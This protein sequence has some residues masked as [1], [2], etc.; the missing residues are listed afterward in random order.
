MLYNES[1]HNILTL[2]GKAHKIMEYHLLSYLAMLT[3]PV[4]Q[5]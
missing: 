4:H 3:L 1:K 5:R 2:V